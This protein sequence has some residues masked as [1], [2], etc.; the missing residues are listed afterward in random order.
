MHHEIWGPSKGQNS[1]GVPTARHRYQNRSA[2]RALLVIG[3]THVGS[4]NKVFIDSPSTLTLRASN[5]ADLTK[6]HP[7]RI[8]P[9]FNQGEKI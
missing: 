6:K 1:G 8:P 2:C 9:A 5:S 7:A 4:G 3:S